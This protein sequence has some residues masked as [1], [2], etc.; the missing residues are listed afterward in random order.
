MLDDIRDS[1]RRYH[2]L[3]YAE[4]AEA[5]AFLGALSRVLASPQGAPFL[6]GRP[7]VEVWAD[8]GVAEVTLFLSEAALQAAAAAFA[9]IPVAATLGRAD[10][11]DGSRLV[12]E[13]PDVRA[14]GLEEAQ[15][16]LDNRGSR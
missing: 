8:T 4:I 16:R 13:G 1:E 11:P 9:P 10:L 2:A 12:L 15:R 6:T 3:R 5:A 14:M 7:P